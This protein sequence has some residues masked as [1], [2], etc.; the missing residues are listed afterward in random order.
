[1]TESAGLLDK[2]VAA[3]PQSSTGDR[4]DERWLWYHRGWIGIHPGGLRIPD[5]P[6]R[7]PLLYRAEQITRQAFGLVHQHQ[8]LC[9]TATSR[10]SAQVP[11]VPG[12]SKNSEGTFRVPSGR[13]DEI[14]SPGLLLGSKQWTEPT[15]K[16]NNRAEVLWNWI[17][18]NESSFEILTNECFPCAPR[19]LRKP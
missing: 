12:L 5:V 15:N 6:C 16:V 10:P 11:R 7:G 17:V 3:T 4:G 18:F 14:S 9:R 19:V 13:L 8:R 2:L 1:M